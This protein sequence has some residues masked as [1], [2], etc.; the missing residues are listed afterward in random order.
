MNVIYKSSSEFVA[1]P[2]G[3][4]FAN[5]GTTDYLSF[6]MFGYTIASCDVIALADDNEAEDMVSLRKDLTGIEYD[7][8]FY[9]RPRATSR[10]HQDCR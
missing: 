8:R 4:F 3:V 2:E 5:S 9:Q 1:D 10:A 7:I 6:W